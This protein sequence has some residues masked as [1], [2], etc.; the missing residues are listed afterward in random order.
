MKQSIIYITL[1]LLTISLNLVAAENNKLEMDMELGWSPYQANG[2]QWE[3]GVK[4]TANLHRPLGS[5]FKFRNGLWIR[6]FQNSL[7]KK[8]L[9]NEKTSGFGLY[10][11]YLYTHNMLIGQIDVGVGSIPTIIGDMAAGY[12]STGLG[13]QP[14]TK[15]AIVCHFDYFTT[16]SKVDNDNLVILSPS[17]NLK[18]LF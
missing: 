15:T 12:L 8:S 4:I 14:F 5:N 16:F 13:I 1:T 7:T 11:G 18:Y 9:N 3:S 2:T 6:L 10:H 17:I